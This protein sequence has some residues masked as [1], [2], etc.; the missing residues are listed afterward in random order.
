MNSLLLTCDCER[1]GQ[2]MTGLYAPGEGGSFVIW[3]VVF[4]SLSMLSVMGTENM[5]IIIS[6]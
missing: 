3:T 6:V 1:S 5:K 4:M 2:L